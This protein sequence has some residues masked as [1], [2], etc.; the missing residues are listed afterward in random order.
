MQNRIRSIVLTAVGIGVV[1]TA[2]VAAQAV[3]EAE[4]FTLVQISGAALPA[5]VEEEGGCREEVL[6]G[7]LTLEAGEWV[8]AT[9]ERETCG[10]QVEEEEEREEG[11]YE[12]DRETI[13]FFDGDEDDDDAEDDDTE[14]DDEDEID[15]DD[16]ATGARTADGLTI[17]LQDAGTLQFRR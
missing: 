7:T 8:L 9:Q 16:L 1:S 10:D 15:V 2:A 14:D 5:V 3:S 6:G 12:V 17:Q 4:T 11:R 13:R